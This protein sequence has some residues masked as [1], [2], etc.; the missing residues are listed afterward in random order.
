MA[1]AARGGRAA[2]YTQAALL[3]FLRAEP[4]GAALLADHAAALAADGAAGS[5]ERCAAL[6]HASRPDGVSLALRPLRPLRLLITTALRCCYATPRVDDAALEALHAI[7]ASL[8][9]RVDAPHVE[10]EEAAEAA[11]EGGA[12]EVPPPP[13]PGSKEPLAELLDRLDVLEHHL[14]AQQR[15][16]EYRLVQEMTAF[17]EAGSGATLGLSE[18]RASTLLRAMGRHTARRQPPASRLQW[19]AT[20]DDMTSLRELACAALPA[21]AAAV[22][23]LQALLLAEQ[24][25]HAADWLRGAGGAAVPAA[26]A[27]EIVLAAAREL[28]NSAASADAQALEQAAQC[29]R[30]LPS[31][32]GSEAAKEEARLI[33]GVR[34]LD[35]LGVGRV[36]LEVRLKPNAQPRTHTP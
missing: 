15:L 1:A 29:L 4:R 2:E 33:E 10:E 7:Y 18:E 31:G 14:S 3:P 30:V 19:E 24:F 34:L 16:G 27:E 11:S 26:R 17:C 35:R 12:D 5:L 9:G 8:P 6:I 20:L 22:E 13:S 28:F 32:S 25:R 36:P 21:E 23:W